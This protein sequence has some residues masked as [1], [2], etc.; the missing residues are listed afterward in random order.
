MTKKKQRPAV[1]D[2]VLARFREALDRKQSH[3]GA[4]DASRSGRSAAGSVHGP[5]A[6]AS[7]QMFRRKSGG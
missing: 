4:E 5:Q 7:Q 6:R 2:D 1:G 3:H